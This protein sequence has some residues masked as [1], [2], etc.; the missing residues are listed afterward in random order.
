MCDTSVNFFV[1]NGFG[2]RVG[3]TFTP[4]PQSVSRISGLG[5]SPVGLASVHAT[6]ISVIS[7]LAARKQ[8]DVEALQRQV[9]LD[10]GWSGF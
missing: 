3:S 7:R 1:Q 8:A 10:S 2:V 5:S 6:C 9:S 4:P